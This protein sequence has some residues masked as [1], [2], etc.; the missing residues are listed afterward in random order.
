MNFV[1]INLVGVEV[2]FTRIEVGRGGVSDWW[3]HLRKHLGRNESK[4]TFC[5][6]RRGQ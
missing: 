4:T 3:R 2:D 5:I 1:N 6:D